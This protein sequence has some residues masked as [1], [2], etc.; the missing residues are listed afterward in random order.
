MHLEQTFLDNIKTALNNHNDV[1]FVLVNYDSQDDLDN[2]VAENLKDYIEKKI[3]R[4]V[5]LRG[6]P[7]FSDSHSKNVGYRYASGDIII[8]LDADNFVNDGFMTDILD[9]FL[10]K[11]YYDVAWFEYGVKGADGRVVFRREL[12]EM[13]NGYNES[14]NGWG[15]ADTDIKKRIEMIPNKKMAFLKKE[16]ALYIE[17]SNL[18]RKNNH[19]FFYSRFP[20]TFALIMNRMKASIGRFFHGF[21]AYNKNHK[22]GE[23]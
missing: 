10:G 21:R 14:M 1:E 19:S 22:Y 17:H 8:S 20:I 12:F 3:V 16:N 5:I 11:I 18:L 15:V 7:F 23:H 6:Y 2:W 9:I 4:Y 13:L